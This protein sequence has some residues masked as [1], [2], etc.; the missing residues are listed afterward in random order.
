MARNKAGFVVLDESVKTRE[1]DRVSLVLEQL[2]SML[3]VAEHA[4]WDGNAKA[5]EIACVVQG[6]RERLGKLSEELTELL[7]DAE[8]GTKLIR[9]TREQ[10]DD[11]IGEQLEEPSEGLK[12]QIEAY[13]GD[14]DQ[15]KW[16]RMIV[17]CAAVH[18]AA[19]D[20]QLFEKPICRLIRLWQSAVLGSQMAEEED[21]AKASE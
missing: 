10:I 13:A 12:A 8:F 9:P 16:L 5:E 7:T 19:E 18:Y 17:V 2:C 1:V 4:L 20:L 21:A 14:N 15:L 11:Y 3:S 6:V